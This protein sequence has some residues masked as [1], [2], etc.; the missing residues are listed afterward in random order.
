MEN[1]VTTLAGGGGEACNAPPGYGPVYSIGTFLRKVK[2]DSCHSIF[3]SVA[4]GK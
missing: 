1:I 4:T 3:N 2:H